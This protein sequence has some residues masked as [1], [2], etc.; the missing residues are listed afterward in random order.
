MRR[1]WIAVFWLVTWTAYYTEQVGC[2]NGLPPDAYTGQPANYNYASY[3]FHGVST[4]MEKRFESKK[5]AMDFIA[6][7]PSGTCTDVVILE[8]L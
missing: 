5:E 1:G 7:C 2:Q 3:C 8:V 6:A 4:K